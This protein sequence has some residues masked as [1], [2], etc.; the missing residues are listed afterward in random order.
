LHE[1]GLFYL[2]DAVVERTDQPRNAIRIVSGGTRVELIAS[3]SIEADNWFWR[4]NQNSSDISTEESSF[5]PTDSTKSS[6]VH[7]TLYRVDSNASDTSSS[8]TLIL[9][10]R[11]QSFADVPQQRIGTEA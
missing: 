11:E 3:N 8:N 5:P 2:P 1:L 9:D 7:S 6:A 4:L 10:S